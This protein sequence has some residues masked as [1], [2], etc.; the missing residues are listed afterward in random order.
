MWGPRQV[1]LFEQPYE[2]FHCLR[3]LKVAAVL[4]PISFGVLAQLVVS[5][6]VCMWSLVCFAVVDASTW[7]VLQKLHMVLCP[8]LFDLALGC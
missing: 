2:M 7:L 3:F 1:L 6:M 5:F 8:F 4:E